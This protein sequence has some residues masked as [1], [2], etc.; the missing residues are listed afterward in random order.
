VHARGLNPRENRDELS[1]LVELRKC[2]GDAEV[3]RVTEARQ[4]ASLVEDISN[5]LVDHALPPIQGLPQDPSTAK[6]VLEGVGTFLEC[7]HEGY[8]S[9]VDPW[10]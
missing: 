5:A 8:A 6:D 1:E 10:G 7:L 4:L 3:A 9:G 2:L